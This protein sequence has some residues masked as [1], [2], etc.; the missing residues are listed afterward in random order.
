MHLSYDE[1][2]QFRLVSG[3][4]NGYTDRPTR[5]HRQTGSRLVKQ[6]ARH[7]SIYAGRSAHPLMHILAC[8]QSIYRRFAPSSTPRANRRQTQGKVSLGT[9]PAFCPFEFIN[10]VLF[11]Q[12]GCILP[13]SRIWSVTKRSV[14]WCIGVVLFTF[15]CGRVD[16]G[17]LVGALV[18]MCLGSSRTRG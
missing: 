18:L 13:R 15:R 11:S 7:P 14:C 10:L 2:E 17:E 8:H 4:S 3:R 9:I 1:Y 6:V 5:I 16:S 12:R